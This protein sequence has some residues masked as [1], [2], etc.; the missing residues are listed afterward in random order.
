[1]LLLRSEINQFSYS[2]IYG[3]THG[4]VKW[5]MRVTSRSEF[6]DFGKST[7]WWESG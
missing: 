1:V 7:R 4:F 6:E 5:I 2:T 3:M